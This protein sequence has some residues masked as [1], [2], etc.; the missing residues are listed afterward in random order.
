VES[1]KDGLCS[2]NAKEYL[3]KTIS[4]QFRS[5]AAFYA[6][7]EIPLIIT[8]LQLIRIT[9][10]NQILLIATSRRGPYMVF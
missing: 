1:L 6:S 9:A 2:R 4:R 10:E 5:I 8:E 7:D 3:S